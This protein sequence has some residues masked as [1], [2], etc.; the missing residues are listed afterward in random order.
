MK[1]GTPEHLE[2]LDQLD[3]TLPPDHPD[4]AARTISADS[5]DLFTGLSVWGDDAWVGDLYPEKT[6]K[7]DFLENYFNHFNSVELNSTFYNI[8]KTN[9]QNWA[10]K[11]RGQSFRFCPKFNRRISHIK[12]LKDE[13]YE[14]TDYFV[15]MCLSFGDNLGCT[16]LQMPENFGPKW[17][18]RLKGFLE[19]V[20]KEFPVAVELRHPEWF[21]GE[22]FDETFAMFRE[23]NRTAVITD[24]ALKRDIIHQRLTNNRVFVRFAGYRDHPSNQTRLTEWVGRLKTWRD[25]GISEVYFFC[26]HEDEAF[27]PHT[28]RHFISRANDELGVNLRDPFQQ[29]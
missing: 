15:E 8:K 27:S 16:F 26:K 10:E 21:E 28:A 22:V 13:V 17:F 6:K 25:L 5:F 1:F 4:N 7:K 11:A 12:R 18:D 19:H 29:A 20:P 24:T 9:M 14:L 2:E 3:L 23:L